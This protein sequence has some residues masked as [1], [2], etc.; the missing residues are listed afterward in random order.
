MADPAAITPQSIMPPY[1]FLLERE[2]EFDTIQPRIDVM[3]MLG[4]P[5]GKALYQ[6]EA[7]AREQANEIASEIETH[8]GPEG[9]ETKQ[10][11]ALVAYLQRL[12]TDIK[13]AP[14]SPPV[15]PPLARTAKSGEVR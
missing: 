3:A 10:I 4:V 15:G 14:L 6:A 5:Y 9:L 11:I 8:G 1:A 12:G 13:R 7:M 2:L